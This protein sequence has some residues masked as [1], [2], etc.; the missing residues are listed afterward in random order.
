MKK[1]PRF[2]DPTH[3]VFYIHLAILHRPTERPLVRR[4][5][6]QQPD[7]EQ[8]ETSMRQRVPAFSRLLAKFITS[9]ALATVAPTAY[10]QAQPQLPPPQAPPTAVAPITPE[11]AITSVLESGHTL[12]QNGRWADAL[13]KYEEA[14]HE[15]PEEPRLQAR[16]DVAR[17]HYSLD[18]RYED[19]SFRD[20]LRTLTP[21]QALD[22][23]TDLLSKIDAHYYTDPPWQQMTQRGANALDIALANE[24][25]LRN[26]GVK[27]RGQQIDQLRSEVSALPGKYAIK[28]ARDASAVASQIAHLI[29]QRVGVSETAS[30]LEFTSAAAGGLDH[31]SAFL[32]ADQLRDIYS[33]IE[34]NFVGLGVELKADQGALLIVHVIPHSPAE[35]AG[36]HEGDRISAVDGQQTKSLSTDEAASLLTGE[37]GSMC[38]VTVTS[39]GQAQREVTVRRASVDVPSLENVK[40]IDP[41]TGVAYVRIPAFQKTTPADL[42]NALWDLHK[43][44]MRS[45]IIDLRGNPG[46]LLTASVEVADKFIADGGIVSTKGRSEPE[47]FSYRA[48]RPG[49]W[50]VPLVVLIDGDSASASEIF[51]GAIKDSGRGKIVGAR[52]YGKGSVQGIFPL[53]KNGAGARITTAKFFSPLNHPIAN[54]GVTPDID[55]RNMATVASSGQTTANHYMVNFRPSE[56]A[57]ASTTNGVTAPAAAPASTPDKDRVLDIAVGVARDMPP[58]QL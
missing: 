7:G 26:Q 37:E 17:L 10:G 36:I 18:Q 57:T 50:R 21:Q 38:K 51:A 56:G 5:A 6:R 54:V 11:G 55:V 24:N 28:S 35:Q 44:G 48:H 12:E 31:Y 8:Q 49:T 58:V 25:F 42:E 14:L 34:G 47:N 9:W 22:Q 33:Q 43:Q 15:N 3:F 29:R 45:L 53:G 46:G 2:F 19:R 41:A 27:V 32:T 4:A 39:P 52:S 16:F 13:T 30:F 40:I 20:S 1:L 23:Y